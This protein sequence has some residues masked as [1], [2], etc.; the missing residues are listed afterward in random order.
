MVK[1]VLLIRLALI[2]GGQS[3]NDTLLSVKKK[4]PMTAYVDAAEIGPINESVKLLVF[5]AIYHQHRCMQFGMNGCLH[6]VQ[7]LHEVAESHR[8]LK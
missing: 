7:G 5:P 6:S 3:L 4:N 1:R 8:L 2:K